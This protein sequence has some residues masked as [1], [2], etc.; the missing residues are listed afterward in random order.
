[1]SRGRS[2]LLH[3]A[4]GAIL[5]AFA[6]APLWPAGLV[7]ADLALYPAAPARVSALAP[8]ANG[9]LELARSFFGTPGAH[10]DLAVRELRLENALYLFL[11]C[12]VFSALLRR[13]LRAWLGDEVGF[14]AQRA[15]VVILPLHPWCAAAV[16]SAAA[17]GEL[18]GLLFAALAAFAFLRGRQEGEQRWLF[19]SFT[20]ALGAGFSSAQAWLL[21]PLAGILEWIVARRHRSAF[22]RVRTTLSTLAGFALATLAPAV[23][24]GRTPSFE[25]FDGAAL[26]NG[27]TALGRVLAPLN[28]SEP[29]Y[30]RAA[31]AGAALLLMLQ[32]ALIAAR[33][34]PRTWGR[35]ALAWGLLVLVCLLPASNGAGAP[36]AD[37]ASLRWLCAPAIVLGSACAAA[38][39]AHSGWK[40][41]SFPW[42]LALA[43]LAF[44]RPIVHAWA[45]ATRRLES[46]GKEVASAGKDV[47]QLV[48][49]A[50]PRRER[51][52]MLVPDAIAASW[53]SRE[54]G[55]GHELVLA[56]PARLSAWA[57][58]ANFPAEIVLLQPSGSSAAPFLADVLPATRRVQRRAAADER[59]SWRETRGHHQ[60]L[61]LDPQWLH[62]VRARLRPDAP[63]ESRPRISWQ[64]GAE[65]IASA[66]G[67][68]IEG[69]DA[70]EALFDLGR[71]PRWLLCGRVSRVW[72]E[73]FESEVSF[74]VLPALAEPALAAE[75]AEEVGGWSARLAATKPITVGDEALEWSLVLFDPATLES[76]TLAG[77]SRAPGELSFATPPGWAGRV[78]LEWSLEGRLHECVLLRLSRRR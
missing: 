28:P 25:A 76:V 41:A 26:A 22:A 34:A 52:L 53:L 60:L 57:A 7:G 2:L 63:H 67:V 4:A 71:E 55:L 66:F 38:A 50:P 11:A 48:L 1:M 15:A 42:I 8:I 64:S 77:S 59:V 19:A 78:P 68:W 39:T 31:L 75:P 51:G 20:L 44:D 13:T 69:G 10:P 18:L 30:L 32:P 40:R 12:L 36:A 56:D 21:V 16:A 37:L 65:P 70:P 47:P 74:E 43:L 9:S 54:A 17:R 33:S 61:D 62:C 14:A 23:L 27:L 72:L 35:F 45:A 24:A 3:V 5:S 46:L 29:D 58:S 73:G 6:F 49:L